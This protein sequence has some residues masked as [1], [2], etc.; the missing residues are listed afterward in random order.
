MNTVTVHL[1]N[2]LF[3]FK[4]D[5]HNGTFLHSS[6]SIGSTYLVGLDCLLRFRDSNFVYEV[7]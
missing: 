6:P 1:V 2:L 7:G 4:Y 5:R 3:L